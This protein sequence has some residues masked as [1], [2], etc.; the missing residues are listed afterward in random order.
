MQVIPIEDVAVEERQHI[1]E[2]VFR[3][4]HI[5]AGES[6]TLGN[7][8]LMLSSLPDTYYSPRHRHNFD[9]FRYQIEGDF[10]SDGEMKPGSL[11]YFPEGTY[12]GP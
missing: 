4:Q 10:D 3:I 11:G 5:L 1:R 9:Q 7:F 6:D 12:Y 8:A 2:G